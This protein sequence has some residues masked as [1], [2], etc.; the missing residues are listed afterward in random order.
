MYNIHKFHSVQKD[1]KFQY[2]F[3]R[4]C[5]HL[6]PR[7]NALNSPF[8]DG[9]S[10]NFIYFLIQTVSNNSLILLE[11]ASLVYQWYS[12]DSCSIAMLFC[13]YLPQ[14]WSR[15]GEFLYSTETCTNI[16]SQCKNAHISFPSNNCYFPYDDHNQQQKPLWNIYPRY[17]ENVLSGYFIKITQILLNCSV[18]ILRM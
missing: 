14:T 8:S 7:L 4:K 11:G 10:L 2:M 15:K 13:L 6:P 9:M 12:L 3:L 1:T 16:I 17:D 18:S 5:K